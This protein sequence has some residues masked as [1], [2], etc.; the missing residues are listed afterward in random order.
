MMKCGNDRRGQM[1]NRTRKEAKWKQRTRRDRSLRNRVRHCA[2]GAAQGG[3]RTC[4]SATD[5]V[6]C[7]LSWNDKFSQFRVFRNCG[8]WPAKRST[9]ME[10]SLSL[11]WCRCFSHHS[12]EKTWWNHPESVVKNQIACVVKI[13]LCGLRHG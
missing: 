12:Q 2:H 8:R 10:W 7:R 9:T 5:S 13:V 3:A 1:E 6:H 4:R 11:S